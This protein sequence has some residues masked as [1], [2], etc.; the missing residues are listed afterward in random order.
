MFKNLNN[1]EYVMKYPWIFSF[2]VCFVEVILWYER[3]F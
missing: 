2:F 1:R 3:Y